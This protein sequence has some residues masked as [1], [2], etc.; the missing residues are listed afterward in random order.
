M[1]ARVSSNALHILMPCAVLDAQAFSCSVLLVLILLIHCVFAYKR[2]RSTI[3]ASFIL[4]CSF[5]NE[6]GLT[7]RARHSWLRLQQGRPAQRS[8]RK[9]WALLLQLLLEVRARHRKCICLSWKNFI[10]CKQDLC[11]GTIA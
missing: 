4:Q 2:W 6:L 8:V 11:P 9:E 3:A 1:C 7:S 10:R 5:L